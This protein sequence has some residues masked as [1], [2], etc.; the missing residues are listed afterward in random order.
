MATR[1]KARKDRDEAPAGACGGGP[2]EVPGEAPAEVSELAAVCV[3]AVHRSL[4]VEL[5]HGP[6]SIPLLDHY[7]T[8]LPDRPRAPTRDPVRG[9][10]AA[11]TGAYF[12]EVVRRLFPARWRLE[13]GA[14]P[15]D[16]RLELRY[17]FLAFSPVAVAWEV[18]LR[19]DVL[20]GAAAFFL[21]EPTRGLVAE[22]LD[23]LPRVTID[24]YYTFA[25][26]LETL[27]L[28]VGWLAERIQLS[29][30]PPVPIAPRRY[31]EFF[32]RLKT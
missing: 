12:G 13:P 26:R 9:L 7:L 27:V 23:S 4:G 22:R 32:R 21:E 5:D 20:E 11:M 19:R 18:L 25:Q 2:D 16:W 10:V 1:R 24:D 15:L 30:K 31:A 14:E 3:R 17:C 29:G 28:T 6:D 8:L